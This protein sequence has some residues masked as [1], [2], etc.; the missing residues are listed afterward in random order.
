MTTVELLLVTNEKPCFFSGAFRLILNE[1]IE[2]A[3]VVR[4]ASWRS[5]QRA[6]PPRGLGINGAAQRRAT[7]H[8]FDQGS[9]RNW[10]CRFGRRCGGTII[11]DHHRGKSWCCPHMSLG[12]ALVLVKFERSVYVALGPPSRVCFGWSARDLDLQMFDLTRNA[13]NRTIPP[14]TEYHSSFLTIIFHPDLSLESD[15]RSR[16]LKIAVLM[17]QKNERLF[18]EAMDS[19]LRVSVRG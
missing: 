17:M 19:V 12:L 2:V 15:Q 11:G 3:P 13:A 16:K 9:A 14:A 1:G 18:I 8:N 5:A 10:S 6:A 7:E 4:T